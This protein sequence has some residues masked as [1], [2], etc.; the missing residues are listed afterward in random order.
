MSI[1][2]TAK[3]MILRDGCILLHR[4]LDEGSGRIYHE[5]PG[6]GQHTGETLE[7]ALRREVLEE[8]GLTITRPRLVALA[9]EIMEDEDLIARYPDY[10]HRLFCIFRAEL[11]DV[12]ALPPTEAD[13]DQMETLWVP[14]E[15]ADTLPFRPRL[16]EGRVS[17]IA[18][19]NPDYL[20]CSR[21]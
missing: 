16:L 11:A 12:P 1:R 18:Q 20:G 8:T 14:L 21:L 15:E 2:T 7:D 4:C 6:G 10:F 19:G 5:L 9:E 17:K 3:A 13:M